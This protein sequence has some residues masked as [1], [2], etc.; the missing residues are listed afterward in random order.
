MSKNTRESLAA[1][2]PA[3]Y[4]LHEQESKE[5]YQDTVKKGNTQTYSEFVEEMRAGW[6]KEM[7]SR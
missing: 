5:T 7:L 3:I 4:A 1:Q 2:W 6:I